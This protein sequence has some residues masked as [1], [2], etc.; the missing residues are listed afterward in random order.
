MAR[1]TQS[2]T[3]TNANTGDFVQLSSTYNGGYVNLRVYAA[4]HINY[5]IGEYANSAA[6]VS[7]GKIN[8]I[9]QTTAEN[10]GPVDPKQMWI[11]SNGGAASILYWDTIS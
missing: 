7:G 9:F 1:F 10:F 5:C 6:V 3:A 4:A 8:I 2:G 11:R